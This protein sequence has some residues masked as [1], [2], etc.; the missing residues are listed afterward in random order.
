MFTFFSVSPLYGSDDPVFIEAI[1]K[2]VWEKLNRR[3]PFEVNKELVGI[4]DKHREIEPLLE[5]G[6]NNVKILVLWGMGG[7]GKTTLAKSLY[8]KHCSQFK[9][10]CFLEDVRGV[11]IRSGLNVARKH[12]FST[13]LEI[14]PDAPYVE[15]PISKRK[16]ECEKSLIVLDDVSTLEE[17]E[18][19]DIVNCLG[20]G[21][22][23]I[24]TTRDKQICS[25]FNECA[26]YKVDGLGWYDSCELF[27]WNAFQ[28]KH[29]KVGYEK[30]SEIAISYCSGNPLALKV[31][32]ANLRTKSTEEWKSELDK[33]KKIPNTKTLDV[34]KLSFNDLGSNEQDIFLDSACF[35]N[36]NCSNTS[37]YLRRKLEPNVYSCRDYLTS[38][39]NASNFYAE[40]GIGVLLDKSFITFSEL[41]ESL[42][43]HNLLEELG[44]DIVKN[45]APKHYG[46]RSRLWDPEEVCDV[47]KNSKVSGRLD[48][49]YMKMHA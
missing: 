31:L 37:D 47:L 28:R 16:L 2:D 19:L 23:V 10:H 1:V 21:S 33:L 14:R 7:M 49:F 26:I 25:Q 22:I 34:L 15:T 8:A 17:A 11:S 6:S 40:S 27:Y 39:W 4:K 44:R 42:E 18:N 3:C 9:R 20:P 13:L 35:F 48:Y 24:V 43:M 29:A 38:L 36:S 30:L 41:D 46:K 12:L 32:G 45:E 5:I